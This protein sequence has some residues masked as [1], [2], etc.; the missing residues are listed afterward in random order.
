MKK[1]T[2]LN[3]ET[4]KKSKLKISKAKQIFISFFE[5]I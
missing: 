3:K 1:Y 4:I 2:I 5:L